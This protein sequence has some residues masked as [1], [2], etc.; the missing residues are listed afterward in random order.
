M[1]NDLVQQ[2]K[3]NWLLRRL[4]SVSAP[5]GSKRE[6]DTQKSLS[7]SSS[8]ANGAKPSVNVD[9]QVA[10][11]ESLCHIN[12]L[13]QMSE[14]QSA[15]NAQYDSLSPSFTAPP[16]QRGA[17][18]LQQMHTMASSMRFGGTL[19]ASSGSDLDQSERKDQQGTTGQQV[20]GHAILAGG[21]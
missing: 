10:F 11:L 7:D 8:S 17:F 19:G 20:G 21:V 13:T 9:E 1:L 12:F 18:Q 14:N 3:R 16:H 6:L 2:A 15:F 4:S 5:Q